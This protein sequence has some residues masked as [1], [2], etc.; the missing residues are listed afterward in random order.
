MVVAFFTECGWVG[1]MVVW[2]TLLQRAVPAEILGRVRS[3]DWFA[4]I[5][6]VPASFAIVGPLAHLVGTR[7]VLVACGVVA[8]V[9]TFAASRLRGMRDTEGVVVLSTV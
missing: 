5:A 6:L 8:L 7:E 2:N 4:S 1:G 9:L 3:V